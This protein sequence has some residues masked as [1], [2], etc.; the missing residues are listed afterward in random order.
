M[1]CVQLTKYNPRSVTWPCSASPNFIGHRGLIIHDG[2]FPYFVTDTGA[3]VDLP[4]EIAEIVDPMIKA[5]QRDNMAPC[6]EPRYPNGIAIYGHLCQGNFF[7]RFLVDLDVVYGQRKMR[8]A[9]CDGRALLGRVMMMQ[10]LVAADYYGPF[11]M[12]PS[13]PVLS[14]YEYAAVCA[15]WMAY[16]LLECPYSSRILPE[17]AVHGALLTDMF[18]PYGQWLQTLWAPSETFLEEALL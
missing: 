6:R 5:A 18:V 9:L 2:T 16:P 15:K 11:W 12:A 8:S 4:D 13:R 14:D 3:L 1:K 17:T 10:G 7:A